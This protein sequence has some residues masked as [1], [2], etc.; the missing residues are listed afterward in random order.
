MQRQ[1][2]GINVEGTVAVFVSGLAVLYVN[3]GTGTAT[4]RFKLSQFGFK[5]SRASGYNVWKNKTTTFSGITV[6]LDVG[7]TGLL[8]MKGL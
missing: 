4:A 3:T 2:L 6:T 1:Q 8:V 5:T 7:Q